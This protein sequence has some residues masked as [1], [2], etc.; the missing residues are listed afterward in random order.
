MNKL[1]QNI[2]TVD[3]KQLFN[4]LEVG[5]RMTVIRLDSRRL[6]LISPILIDDDL[7]KELAALGEVT[8]VIAPNT[9]HHL[10]LR[11]CCEQY[12]DAK[13]FVAEGLEEKYKDLGCQTLTGISPKEWAD[14]LEQTVYD[15]YAVFETSGHAEVNEVV[16][17]HKTSKTLIVTDAAYHIA[18]SS[19]FT[20]RL[21]TKMTGTYKVLAPSKLDQFATK[22]RLDAQTAML[23][24][25]NWDFD[26]V[27]MAHGEIIESG[28]K[29]KLIEGS[30]WL[31]ANPQV[32]KSVEPGKKPAMSCCG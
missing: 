7:A 23:R 21:L 27:V 20:L 24:I 26:A 4:G 13:V 5:T 18:A 31:L 25:L 14:Q 15:G 16:F 28:G 22:R 2:W 32:N 6:M 17:Y 1:N 12:P 3:Q 19:T 8:C 9:Y 11:A 30:Q 10:Y 29:A